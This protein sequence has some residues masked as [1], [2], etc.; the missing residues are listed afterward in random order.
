[1]AKI[2]IIVENEIRQ[3]KKDITNLRT[4]LG[5]KDA[6]KE[7]LL[8]F[9]MLEKYPH[10]VQQQ[11]WLWRW[12]N[13]DALYTFVDQIPAW[14]IDDNVMATWALGMQDLPNSYT[15]WD[16]EHKEAGMALMLSRAPPCL[17]AG[18]GFQAEKIYSALV[19]FV[20]PK[21][22]LLTIKEGAVTIV[23][24]TDELKSDVSILC[25][26]PG[27]KYGGFYPSAINH[28]YLVLPYCGRKGKPKQLR[29]DLAICYNDTL[30]VR[31]LH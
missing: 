9:E 16:S 27:H 22:E 7:D 18:E 29:L 12:E 4:E 11:A 21:Q 14:V 30:L 1:M 23:Q 3:L 5:R 13:V 31:Q 10:I 2:E 17:G 25:E 24:F 26:L 20:H 19:V 15:N 8:M 28:A 6:A